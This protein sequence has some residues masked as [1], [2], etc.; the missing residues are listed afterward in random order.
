M[1]NASRI[2]YCVQTSAAA[3]L[4]VSPQEIADMISSGLTPV[5]TILPG[6]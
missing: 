3:L 1:I 2:V 4:E 5:I 6:E